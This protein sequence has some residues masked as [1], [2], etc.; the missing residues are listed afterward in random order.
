MKFQIKKNPFLVALILCLIPIILFIP[1]G[2]I[3][4]GEGQIMSIIIFILISPVIIILAWASF[5][6][7]H[8][9]SDTEFISIFGY[10]KIKIPFNEINKVRFSLNPMSSPAWT[11]KRLRIDYKK[12]E[13]ALLSLPK[14]EELFL[15]EL[16]KRCPQAEIKDSKGNL[17]SKYADEN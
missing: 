10:I 4:E 9:F 1:I 3:I 13:F 2:S 7:Y 11:F 12:F 6:S 16:Q 17:F 8:E 14:E 5:H 15:S